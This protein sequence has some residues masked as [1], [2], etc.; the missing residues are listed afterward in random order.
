MDDSRRRQ[1]EEIARRGRENREKRRSASNNPDNKSIDLISGSG[2]N[3][4]TG[5]GI[6]TDGKKNPFSDRVTN[7]VLD[8][9]ERTSMEQSLGLERENE[10][11]FK[12]SFRQNFSKYTT[13]GLNKRGITLGGRRSDGKVFIDHEYVNKCRRMPAD[14]REGELAGISAFINERMD[15]LQ[16]MV[17][18]RGYYTGTTLSGPGLQM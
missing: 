14:K 2:R 8:S 17:N 10:S 7:R 12:K 11:K 4:K 5:S 13:R 6:K 18:E 9:V 15:S 3:V 1:M 16:A